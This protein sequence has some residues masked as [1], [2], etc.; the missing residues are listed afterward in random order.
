MPLTSPSYVTVTG[1][2]GPGKDVT[3]L[4]INNVKKFTLDTT[5]LLVTIE[6]PDLSDGAVE[7]DISEANNFTVDFFV[8]L[9]GSRNFNID[10]N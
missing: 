9:D 1:K 8:N 2:I 3:T 6:S 10:I 7:V 4:G 5:G